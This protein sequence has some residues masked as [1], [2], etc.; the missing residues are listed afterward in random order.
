MDVV[1]YNFTLTSNFPSVSL[2]GNLPDNKTAI[3]AANKFLNAISFP[4][5]DI[6]TSKTQVNYF[7]IAAGQ[8]IPSTSFSRR[9]QL[10]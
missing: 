2:P 1:G 9:K 4:T 5:N 7:S 3:D 8:L 10:R 6:D